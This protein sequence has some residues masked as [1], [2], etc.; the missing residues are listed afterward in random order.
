[1][2]IDYDKEWQEQIYASADELASLVNGDWHITFV[3]DSYGKKMT[4]IVIEYEDP[5][6]Y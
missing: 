2:M 4:R 3:V 6:D 1:M 5:A